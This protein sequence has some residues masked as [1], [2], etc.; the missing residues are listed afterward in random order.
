MIST[1]YAQTLAYSVA[2]ST[3]INVSV[4]R[5]CRPILLHIHTLS[6]CFYFAVDFWLFNL[7]IS[8]FWI[9]R[10]NVN[11]CK[12]LYHNARILVWKP[13]PYRWVD[14]HKTKSNYQSSGDRIS[15]QPV[16]LP[17]LEPI[18]W[19]RKG[20]QIQCKAIRHALAGGV[21]ALIWFNC[22]VRRY[23]ET[24]GEHKIL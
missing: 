6:C 15:I 8:V 16:F 12:T 23:F 7:L 19:T 20:Q 3:K 10:P 2:I 11:V 21:D 22:V 4:P 24:V 1:I 13:A 17:G 9:Q 5:G 18:F 14:S